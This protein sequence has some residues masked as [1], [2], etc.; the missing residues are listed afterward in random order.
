MAATFFVYIHLCRLLASYVDPM[1]FIQGHT[2][3]DSRRR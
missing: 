1:A 2:I 3:S